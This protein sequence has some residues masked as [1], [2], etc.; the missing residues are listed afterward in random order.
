MAAYKLVHDG[1]HIDGEEDKYQ[2]GETNIVYDKEYNDYDFIAEG[3][4]G[5]IIGLY[6]AGLGFRGFENGAFG[7]Y[8][9]RY[10]YTKANGEDA[11]YLSTLP[12]GVI[13]G[14]Y[15]NPETNNIEKYNPY[16]LDQQLEWAARADW[17]VSTYENCNHAPAVEIVG[18]KDVTAAPG[19]TVVLKLAV[20]DPDGDECTESWSV[21]PTGGI[22]QAFKADFFTWTAE[23]E[24][25]SFTIPEDAAAGDCF[26]ITARVRD[27][28]DA[29]MTRYAQFMIVVA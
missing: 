12:G 25:V 9:G 27:N 14:Q 23:G 5:S 18:D 26:C 24:E 21:D 29:V 4:S 10:S 8:A 17:C 1:Q 11:G 28:A 19:E 2:F 22:Y 7:R 3:D 15:V 20:S 13:P 16:L 6:N